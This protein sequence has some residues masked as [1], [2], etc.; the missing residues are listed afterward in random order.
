MA[1]AESIEFVLDPGGICTMASIDGTDAHRMPFVIRRAMPRDVPALRDMQRRSLRELSLGFYDLHQVEAFL[2]YVGTV[3][4]A[5]VD[6]R[7][8]YVAE[9]GGWLAGSGGWSATAPD[10]LDGGKRIPAVV[11][12]PY[13]PRVRSLFV[14]PDWA[15]RGV[16]RRI[17]QVTENAI[18][19]TGQYEVALDA[20]LPGVPLYEALGYRSVTPVDMRLPDGTELR[21]HH[22]R[23]VLPRHHGS[24]ANDSGT[25]RIGA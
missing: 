25:W 12:E 15:R 14:H 10:Y 16:A 23:K 8:Y 9:V 24:A 4:E 18:R 19:S 1:A 7:N 6:E 13:I 17:M 2:F 20:T 21:F 5:V 11:R 3:E 22:M